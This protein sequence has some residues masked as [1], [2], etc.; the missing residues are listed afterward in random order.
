MKAFVFVNAEAWLRG[1]YAAAVPS[2]LLCKC[3][4]NLA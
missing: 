1:D 3:K 4:F 2:N